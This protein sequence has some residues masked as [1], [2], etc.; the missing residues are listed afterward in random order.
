MAVNK[1]LCASCFCF[2]SVYSLFHYQVN[3][4]RII[5]E[6]FISKAYAQGVEIGSDVVAGGDAPGAM[7]AFIWN[8]GL[9][10]V[11]VLLF[12]VLLIAPQQKRFKEHSAMLSA[13][14]KGDRVVTG[15]GLVG[16]VDKLVDDSEV[17]VDL[18]NGLKVTALRSTLQTGA[19]V[20]NKPAANDAKKA[21]K[22]KTK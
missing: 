5:E 1:V 9:V 10:G 22:K 19:A 11:L 2:V 3:F 4:T 14:K 18:G 21:D 20:L 12:Y 16:S 15:G 17:I 13:L 7:E 6:M 8:M